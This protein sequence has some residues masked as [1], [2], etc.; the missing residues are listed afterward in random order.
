MRTRKLTVKVGSLDEALENFK[1]VWE[2]AEAEEKL[3]TSIEIVG[4]ENATLLIKTLTPRRLEL[5]Q[6]L[7]TIGTHSIR[8][9]AKALERDYSNVHQDVEIL[10]KAGLLLQ[11]KKGHYS[12]PWDAI[13]TEIPM[14]RE[15]DSPK[16]M[17]R[18]HFPHHSHVLHR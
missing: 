18:S 14:T 15:I 1:T 6:K 2:K 4:F 11:D 17:S 16:L 5:L 10:K 7:H 9:L 12:M 8:A 13:V 3:T